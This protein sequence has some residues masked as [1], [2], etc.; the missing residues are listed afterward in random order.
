MQE[1]RHVADESGRVRE[2]LE[3]HRRVLDDRSLEC[4]EDDDTQDAKDERDKYMIGRPCV[5]GTAPGQ[6]EDERGRAGD[7]DD[8]TVRVSGSI[9]AHV[10]GTAQWSPRVV[11]PLELLLERRLRSLD[12]QENDDERECETGKGQIDWA[13]H[14]S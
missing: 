13:R 14:H 10:F 4:E 11:H 1:A 5:S 9:S 7:K 2:D 12:V 6:P 8:V 3:G